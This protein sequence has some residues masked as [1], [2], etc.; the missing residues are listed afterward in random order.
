VLR[1]WASEGEGQ[2]VSADR[3]FHTRTARRNL[4]QW[5]KYAQ[6]RTRDRLV[7]ARLNLSASIQRLSC[8]LHRWHHRVHQWRASLARRWIRTT[9]GHFLSVSRGLKRVLN[10][11]KKAAVFARWRDQLRWIKWIG[12]RRVGRAW[13]Q[14]RGAVSTSMQ[15]QRFFHQCAAS[16]NRNLLLRAFGGWVCD[17]LLPAV[18]SCCGPVIGRDISRRWVCFSDG[19]R[20]LLLRAQIVSV[21]TCFSFSFSSC[22]WS[23]PAVYSC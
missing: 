7:T 12:R 18:Y 9:F 13:R 11:Q 16:R 22:D 4:R 14:W 5:R 8:A 17:W 21:R 2:R 20:A 23:L 19:A 1:A 3:H 15:G 10:S 6:G